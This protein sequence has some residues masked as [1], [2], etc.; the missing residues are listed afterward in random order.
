MKIKQITMKNFFYLL[1]VFTFSA[2]ITNAQRWKAERT[3]LVFGAGMSHFM[4]DLGG[5]GKEA[6]HFFGVRDMDFVTT[7]PSLFVGYRYRLTEEI[8]FEPRITYA[9]LSG[10][11]IASANENRRM[12]NLSFRTNLWQFGGHFEYA[13]LK[14]KQ[15]PRYSFSSLRALRNLSA[16]VILGGGI[17]YYNPKA[18]YTDGKWV[19]LRPLHTEG[20]GQAAY[21]LNFVDAEGVNQTV[22]IT[23]D[24]EYKKITAELTIGLGMK[25]NISRHWAIGLEITNQ[26]TTTDYLDDAHDRYYNYT[27]MGTEPPSAETLYFADRH[28]DAEAPGTLYQTGDKF[29]GDPT[30]KDAYI[31]TLITAYYKFKNTVRGLPKF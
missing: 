5:G 25:Y 20:Q 29:R 26:Y 4:G 11:D 23:P 27:Q 17:A 31:L 2:G 16:F 21:T 13:F 10:K 19:A 14:E 28:I 15:N 12:R 22:E 7:R 9:R 18:E 24:A 6:A 8:A 3:S 30:Y 1:I